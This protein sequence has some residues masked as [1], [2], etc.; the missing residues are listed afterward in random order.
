MNGNLEKQA[1]HTKI[2]ELKNKIQEY[3]FDKENQK[4]RNQKSDDIIK[5]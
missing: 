3:E 2:A 5:R 1:L 4:K